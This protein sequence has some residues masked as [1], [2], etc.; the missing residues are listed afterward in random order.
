M[1]IVSCSKFFVLCLLS[2]MLCISACVPSLYNK[3]SSMSRQEIEGAVVDGKTT[4]SDVLRVFGEPDKK[5]FVQAHAPSMAELGVS[6]PQ[7]E[8]LN[9]KLGHKD[10]GMDAAFEIWTYLDRDSSQMPG[11][12]WT[13]PMHISSEAFAKRFLKVT[14]DDKGIVKKHEY[15]SRK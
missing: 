12:D 2:F 8:K 5:Q 10:Q 4:K 3:F 15:N 9:R 13:H 14:F 7:F 11:G 1:R 6:N